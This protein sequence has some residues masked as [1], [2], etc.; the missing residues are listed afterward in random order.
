MEVEPPGQSY[1]PEGQH[2]RRRQ[3]IWQQIPGWVKIAAAVC[4]VLL[5]ISLATG[6]AVIEWSRSRFSSRPTPVTEKKQRID[7]GKAFDE[8]V[9]Q[10]HPFFE[11]ELSGTTLNPAT[12]RIEGS[13]LNKSERAYTNIKIMFALPSHDLAAQDS[14][15]VTIPKLAPGGQAKF[16]SDTLPVGVSQWAL[17]NLTGTPAKASR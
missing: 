3:N 11:L 2:R 16:I 9:A 14:T 12:R 13:I 6:N 7:T 17:V 15:T 1:T 8:V 5:A 10:V 4:L